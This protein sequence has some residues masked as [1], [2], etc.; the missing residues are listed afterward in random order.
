MD[1]N[2]ASKTMHMKCNENLHI[3]IHVCCMESLPLVYPILKVDTQV[4]EDEFVDGYRMGNK[5]LYVYVL[6][7][8]E[9]YFYVIEKI[10]IIW[11]DDSIVAIGV[12][13]GVGSYSSG[14]RSSCNPQKGITRI[15]ELPIITVFFEFKHLE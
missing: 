10:S 7:N 5:V 11:K 2:S 6:D 3:F 4:L 15:R 14:S 1:I 13:C 9:N 12:N 8:C